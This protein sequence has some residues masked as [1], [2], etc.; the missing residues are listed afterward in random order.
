MFWNQVKVGCLLKLF[1]WEFVTAAEKRDNAK[2]EWATLSSLPVGTQWESDRLTT[3]DKSRSLVIACTDGPVPSGSGAG[4]RYVAN[5]GE[6]R[7]L[8]QGDRWISGN[9]FDPTLW[10]GAEDECWKLTTGELL[11]GSEARSQYLQ[12]TRCRFDVAAHT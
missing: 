12:K 10:N 6:L 5:G 11:D 3:C 2:R 9:R 1:A 4:F 8:S 7:N